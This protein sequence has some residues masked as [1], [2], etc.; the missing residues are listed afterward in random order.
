MFQTRHPVSYWQRNLYQLMLTYVSGTYESREEY[1]VYDTA[2]MI[3]DI[4]GYLGL[5]LGHSIYSVM[6][7][8]ILT[9]KQRIG[10]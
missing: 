8:T 1:L 7:D 2:S 10:G 4:G 3:G 9:L 6:A 5:L